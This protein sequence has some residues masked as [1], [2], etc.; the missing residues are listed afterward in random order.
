MRQLI[1][2]VLIAITL[3]AITAWGGSS[4]VNYQ[5]SGSSPFATTTD[6]SGNNYGRQT[7]WDQSAAANGWQINTNHAGLMEGAGTAGSASGGI[8]TVQG[9]ASMTPMLVNP[10]TAA[11]W[12][13]GA[14][15][16][17]PPA[18]AIYNGITSSGN[19]TGWDGSVTQRGNWTIACTNCTGAGGTSATDTSTYTGGSSVY[20][21]TGGV[22]NDGLAAL[23]TGQAGAFRVT[24]ARSLHV[25][26]DNSAAALTQLSAINTNLQGSSNCL[27]T[28]NQITN[29]YSNGQTV[30]INCDLHGNLFA[31][32]LL[33][34]AATSAVTNNL[35]IKA[36]SGILFGFNCTAISGGTAGF[37]IAY[38]ATTPGAP[39]ALIGTQVL[40]SCFFDTT[41]RGCS[42]SH[43][44]HAVSYSN[45][46]IIIM[47]TASTPFT[48]TSGSA[49]GFISA[50][51]Q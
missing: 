31:S 35:I 42:L 46:I 34:H 22:F 33:T 37:C 29:S 27:A 15:G 6:G 50:D 39:G 8:L 20:T 23:T 13:V 40:D 44:D 38:N 5:S 47:T 24:S 49:N 25:L 16:A 1:A 14:T 30:P 41:A 43:L 12:A 28:T 7:I 26:D 19:L 10:G 18:N 2:P 9:V 36:S 3:G 45:G 21:P 11:N 32:P 51:Y 48:W 4:T 17:G